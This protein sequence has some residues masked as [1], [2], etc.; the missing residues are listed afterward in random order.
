MIDRR[1]MFMKKKYNNNPSG[2]AKFIDI[3]PRT[4][5]SVYRTIDHL[6]R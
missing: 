5:V 3:N 6:V 2:V 1:F 4:Q